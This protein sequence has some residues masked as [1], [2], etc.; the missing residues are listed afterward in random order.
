M[1][2]RYINNLWVNELLLVLAD[3]GVDVATLTKGV[4]GIQEGRLAVGEQLDVVQARTL[5]H[6]AVATSDR[7]HLGVDVGRSLSPRSSGLLSPL[8]LHSPSVRTGIELLVRYQGLISENGRFRFVDAAD[9][10]VLALEYLPAQS[11]VSVH[12]QHVLSVITATLQS[13][14]LISGGGTRARLVRLP[15]GADAQG[16]A[17]KLKCAVVSDGERYIVELDNTG[18]DD[19]I[20]GR[21]EHLYQLL[22]G[23]ADG[24]ARAQRAG[25]G[26]LEHV[27]SHMDR[28]GLV[29]LDIDT[30]ADAV[31]FR[32]RTL[33]RHL[34]EQGTSFRKLKE[35]LLKEK[36]L[37]LLVVRQLPTEEIVE[38]LGYADVSTL[39]RAFKT[40]FGVTP[41]QFKSQIGS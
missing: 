18:I 9:S 32:K 12:L 17:G 26:F 23:Y 29:R 16:V 41:G 24:L 20:V 30:L 11:S 19:V 21:D 28:N 3:L 5:W 10:G 7:E 4:K 6:R 34:D 37:E 2:H 35:G 15:A 38:V 25:Q 31:G 40:W 14:S 33:Q 13:F 36:V 27:K 1:D 8:L 22:L 39:H